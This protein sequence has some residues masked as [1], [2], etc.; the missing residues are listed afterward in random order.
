MLTMKQFY[1]S[2]PRSSFFERDDILGTSIIDLLKYIDSL[3][4]DLSTLLV[5]ILS[6]YATWCKGTIYWDGR[7]AGRHVGTLQAVWA[8]ATAGL[9]LQDENDDVDKDETDME[10]TNAK[11]SSFNTSWSIRNEYRRRGAET[12]SQPAVTHKAVLEVHTTYHILLTWRVEE[13]DFNM[14]R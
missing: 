2:R 13:D 6:S 10:E 9:E 1:S 5:V 7:V 12:K 11:H 3:P 4:D 8:R 14:L